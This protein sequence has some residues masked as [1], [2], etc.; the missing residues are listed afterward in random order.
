MPT[1]RPIVIFGAGGYAKSVADAAESTG[2]YIVKAFFDRAPS[3][4]QTLLGRP[5]I[6][7]DE[8]FASD[9]FPSAGMPGLGDNFQRLRLADI[10]RSKRPAFE[11]PII[12]HANATLA[13]SAQLGE[14]C[15]LLS[16]AVVGPDAVVGRHGSFWSNSVVEHDDRLGDGVTLA[17]AAALGGTVS[18]GDRTF[19][20]MGAIVIHGRTVG[21]D[22]VIGAGAIVTRDIADLKIAVGHP[23]R[24]IKSRNA[25]DAYL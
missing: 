21:T 13:P 17:P 19:I 16:G 2:L 15:V 24:A 4:G 22:C 8:Y 20:G 7:E 14:G 10:I 18:I 6:S 23:A 5:V 25:G 12:V 9:D 11:F 3:T 1:P